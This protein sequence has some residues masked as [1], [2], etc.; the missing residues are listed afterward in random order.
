MSPVDS[1]ILLPSLVDYL[2]YSDPSRILYSFAKTKDPADG[3]SDVCAEE[4]AR[5]VNR[6]SWFIDQHLG[7][8]V[9]FP[10][11]VYLGPQDLNYAIL[12]LASVKT[13][14]K[15]LLVSPRNTVEAN[16]FLLDKT[17]CDIFLTPPNFPLPVVK[18][19]LDV[20][21]MRHIEI[22]NFHDW[23]SDKHEYDAKPMPY[24]YTKTFPEAKAEPLIVLH[25]SG[26]TGL[27]KPIIMTHGTAAAIAAVLKLEDGADITFPKMMR[28]ERLYMTFPLFHA[29]GIS[30]L[31]TCC[32]YSRY[33]AVLAAFPP[34]AA[35][36]N[37]VHIHGNVQHTAMVPTTIEDL[38][39]EPQYLD[40]LSRLKTITFG[41]GPLPAAVGDLA[42]T[43]TRLLNCLG[44][45]ECG[46][47]A[48]QLCDDPKDWR[49]LRLHP[50]LGYE[51]QHVSDDQY[52]QVMVRQED[53]LPYQGV[54]GTFPDLTE[55]HMKDI[56][57][58][59]PDPAKGDLWLYRGR[60]DDI[61]VFSNGEKINPNGME[62]I[63]NGNPAVKSALVCG[64]GYFQ[65]SLLVEAVSPP[66]SA[67][68]EK[69][70]LDAIWPSV[71]AANEE[72]PSHGRIHR[73]MIVFTSAAKPMLRASKG[74][75]QRQLT[76]SLYASELDAL[77]EAGST[78][79][80]QSNTVDYGGYG[81]V[82]AAVKAI[83]T[84][85]TDI[86]AQNI[87]SDGDLFEHGLDSLQMTALV[88]NLNE[89][90]SF[91]G[92]PPSV[93][94]KTVYAHPN[95]AAL[96]DAISAIIN[97]KTSSN[98]DHQEK[99]EEL[100][101][102]YHK[103]MP[104]SGREPSQKSLAP[105]VVL[106]TGSTGSLGSYILDSLQSD[107]KVSRIYCLCRGPESFSRQ[108]GLQASRGL[109]PLSNK[110]Q[111]LDADISKSNFGLP[112]TVYKDLLDQ[113][114][115]IIHNAW[116]VDFNLSIQSFA[117]HIGFV[118]RLVDFS[119]H[120][121]FGADIFF[122]SSISAVGGLQGTVAEQIFT[123]W[124]TP[125]NS[126]YGQ[127]KFISERLLDAAA[128]EASITSVICRVGQIAGPTSTAG[129]WSKKEWLPSLIAS[130]KYLG[131]L[132]DS[133]GPQ[134][135][136]I[137]WIPVDK[138]GKT[139]VELAFLPERAHEPNTGAS[140][141][142]TVNPLP[143]TW[144]ELVPAISRRLNQG[145]DMEVVPLGTWIDALRESASRTEDIASNPA[146]KL[147]DFYESLIDPVMT[148]LS[149]EHTVRSSPTLATVGPVGDDLMNNWMT[150]WGL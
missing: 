63:I 39:R 85:S 62:N 54:F 18:K 147:L 148:F 113:V 23:F 139:L 27:P 44:T 105:R 133:L 93:A 103:D 87:S 95:V 7:P 45:T 51:Y 127:S 123:D 101:Q 97:E 76:L 111:C 4:F 122:V 48:C 81:S 108:E 5:A 104:L 68:D 41:G 15:L 58:K 141:Y 16:T 50:C 28:G 20:R 88:K 92:K 124:T 12:A 49:Y 57:S 98:E 119:S 130:S 11:F 64:Q 79:V 67:E 8:G 126:G 112:T 40:N 91:H 107:D 55:Y 89:Y 100:Y 99:M 114:T 69:R 86:D 145:K 131:K 83:I 128:R 37:S 137:D 116:Q 71:Q 21:P 77:Y 36:V 9:D 61:I 74:T 140:V 29:A 149:T 60:A 70:L 90:I 26:S 33:T 146:I 6:C 32:L 34:S 19:V 115:H 142:H 134:L 38:V 75:V 65:S 78:S 46:P 72:C 47:L 14:Y 132:P 125:L 135:D 42:I 118:R 144:K 143:T 102:L 43:K 59:H 80:Q 25:T 121:R 109:R 53:Y 66:A 2:A 31:L 56:Y 82:E 52:E 138:L 10:T 84:C 17:K 117:R 22:P 30:M 106:M 110:V 1:P 13:G 94:S 24:P 136:T 35:V 120:S 129:E 150:Q 96:T 3:F 73:N